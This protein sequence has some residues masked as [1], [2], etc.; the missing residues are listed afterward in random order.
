[1]R[2]E[3]FI[4]TDGD[5]I[6]VDWGLKRSKKLVLM[7]HGLESSTDQF[8]MRHSAQYL[9]S[10]GFS[11][12]AMN[13]RGCSSIPNSLFKGYHSGCSHDLKDVI[14]SIIQEYNFEELYLLGFSLGGNIVLKYLA[15]NPEDKFTQKGIAFS[16]P[17]D[18]KSAAIQIGDTFGGIYEKRFMDRLKQ[19]LQL[20][21]KLHPE[22]DVDIDQLM[23]MKKFAEFDDYYTAPA[24]GFL[25]ADD[26]YQKASSL[27]IMN[28]IT[29]PS[30]LVSAYDDPF[31]P[32]KCYPQN[33]DSKAFKTEYHSKGGHLAFV[34]NFWKQTCWYPQRAAEFFMQ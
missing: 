9:E 33:T 30:L 8:Y 25:N 34:K 15:E 10:K 31:L 6:H 21:S 1:M 14:N 28:H 7:L 12:A 18:L 24:N 27:Y 16:S 23:K 22:E 4:L 20:K 32:S 26:Y 29:T 5:F 17:V 3:K 13:Y 19:G 2:R 11:I